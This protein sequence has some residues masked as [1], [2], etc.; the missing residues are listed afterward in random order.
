MLFNS[1]AFA[2][3]LPLVFILYWCVFNRSKRWRNLFLLGVS[4]LFY[5]WWDWRFLS[6]IIISSYVDFWVGKQIGAL[7]ERE[8]SPE[9]DRRKKR[10]LGLSLVT[11][12]GILGFFKY[13]NFFVSSFQELF[14]ASGITLPP[15]TLNI[16]LP[17]GISFYTFQTLSYTLDI[18]RRKLT[19]TKDWVQFFAFVSFFPQLVA[20]PIERAKNLLPQFENR[21]RPDYATFR[22]AMLLIAW[23]F[24]KKLMIADRLAVF[25]DSAFGDSAAATG[26]PMLLGVVL[27]AFQLYLDF[28]AYS[29]IAIGTAGLFGFRLCTNFNRPYLSLSFSNFW[30]RWHISLSSWWM[31][32]LYIPLGGNR[33]GKARKMLNLIIVF[34]VSGLWHGA[35]WNFVVW[36]LLNALFLI[37]FDPLLFK[38]KNS[39]G[40]TRIF[41]SLFIFACWT[42]S[43]SFFRAQGLDAALDCIRNLGVGRADSIVHFGLN[44]MELKLSFLLLS[45]LLAKEIIWEKRGEQVSAFFFKLPGLLRWIFYIAFVLSIVYFGQYGGENENA[46]IYFQ[47]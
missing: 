11:N 34:A 17:I 30:K 44:A 47:F 38:N 45:L 36:G 43:L 25:V 29:D 27:F 42:F 23:G 21:H 16:I 31:D 41:Q 33:K 1:F 18:Y 13:C 24:F 8:S 40:I 9:N 37:V 7:N 35:S 19:P 6:L 26:L 46:F 5:G 22:N 3:F 15:F 28:S 39:K 32:Y 2:V 12:I 20:G 14:A 10:Q 4:Y